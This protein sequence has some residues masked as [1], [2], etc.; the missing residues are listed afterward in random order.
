MFAPCLSMLTCIWGSLGTKRLYIGF[1]WSQNDRKY[2]TLL[3]MDTV[4]LFHE[5]LFCLIVNNEF[6]QFHESYQSIK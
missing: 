5:Y 1:V 6:Y 4:L 3:L 2:V